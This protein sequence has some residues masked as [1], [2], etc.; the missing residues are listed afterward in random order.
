MPSYRKCHYKGKVY[1]RRKPWAARVKIGGRGGI[2]TLLGYY[3]TWEAALE[4]EEEFRRQLG[5]VVGKRT[6]WE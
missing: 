2:D 6:R 4:K 5:M 1:P 3:K